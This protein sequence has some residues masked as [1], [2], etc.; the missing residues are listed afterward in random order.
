[1]LCRCSVV[2]ESNPEGM[3]ST[4]LAMKGCGGRPYVYIYEPWR[5]D[6]MLFETRM[7]QTDTL[8]KYILWDIPCQ[9][10]FAVPRHSFLDQVRYPG[11]HYY[12]RRV[13]AWWELWYNWLGPN[14]FEDEISYF[15]H[16]YIAV[17][18]KLSVTVHPSQKN[19]L[20]RTVSVLQSICGRCA[21]TQGL[22]AQY[23]RDVDLQTSRH[24]FVVLVSM[25]LGGLFK[26]RVCLARSQQS[27]NQWW[28]VKRIIIDESDSA[29]D[30]CGCRLHSYL[31]NAAVYNVVTTRQYTISS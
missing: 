27:M 3:G 25:Q 20:E 8:F 26:L 1:M 28:A 30:K 29:S 6:P 12:P 18:K 24:V 13:R 10:P 19:Y 5:C 23:V 4:F 21:N 9:S 15:W 2:V 14:E 11:G 17:I 31:R 16:Y 22:M 7:K